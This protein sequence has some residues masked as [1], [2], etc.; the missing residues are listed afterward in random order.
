[1]SRQCLLGLLAGIVLAGCGGPKPQVGELGA[2]SGFIG[3]VAAEEPNAALVA[4][5]VLSSGGT[6]AD[7][8]VAAFFTMAVTYPAG[9]SLGSG[10][11]CVYYDATTNTAET[12]SF[13]PGRAAAG[14]RIAVPGSVRGMALLHS[15]YGRLRW[16]QLISPA[17]TLARFGFPVSRA[18]AVRVAAAQNRLAADPRMASL[19]LTADGEPVIE[20]A[21]LVQ[22]Q[23][24]AALSRL[25]GRGVGDL[26][27]G[28]LGRW[29]VDEAKTEGGRIE[30][31]DLRRYRPLWLEPENREVGNELLHH[32]PAAAGGELIYALTG[33]MARQ[34]P[35]AATASVFG[36]SVRPRPEAGEAAFVA[37]DPSGSAVS[38]VFTMNGA[39]GAGRA[40]PTS[41]ILL[42]ASAAP[43]DPQLA[44]MVAANHNTAQAFFAI[45][46]SGGP[47]GLA[48][49]AQVTMDTLTGRLGLEDAINRPRTFVFSGGQGRLSESAAGTGGTPSLTL[50]RIQ[51]FNC[52]DGLKRSPGLCGFA[53]DPR[54]HGLTAGEVF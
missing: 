1:L 14:G 38:C 28:E 19:L 12:L 17:E 26:Y 46:G 11:V 3:G 6:A 31:D 47:A 50:G 45:A 23:L 44:P 5:D 21:T 25:R 24:A 15:R 34:E 43:G 33:A 42:A 8:A 20:G 7:A 30:L 41:G 37:A 52:P 10:G 4:R 35:A 16:T 39:F 2:V 9:A 27:G 53:T 32:P 54:G 36:P 48:A 40:A 29:L 13:L 49:A 18:L 51:V 22:V